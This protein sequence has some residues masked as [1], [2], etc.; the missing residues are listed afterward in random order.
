MRHRLPHFAH[1]FSGGY[2]AGYYS[3][4]WADI[5]AAD[6]W[7]AFVEAPDG[8]W[9][10]AT[11]QRLRNTVLSVGNAVPADEAYRAFRGRDVNPEALM[12][13]RGFDY[14]IS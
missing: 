8:A 13:A 10:R 12:R 14:S 1:I 11:A 9:D 2:S 5:L 7:Q 6:A 3:Y 4:L